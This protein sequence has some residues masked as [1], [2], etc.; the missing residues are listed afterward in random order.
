MREPVA[1]AFFPP[2]RGGEDWSA[3][4]NAAAVGAVT[5]VDVAKANAALYPNLTSCLRE[6]FFG[7]Y[8]ANATGLTFQ[9]LYTNVGGLRDHFAQ[10]W[11]LVASSLKDAS[12]VL[13]FEIINEPW[14]GNIY[15]EHYWFP[16]TWWFDSAYS[17][18]T[19]LT[20]FYRHI[21]AAIREVD[22]EHIIAYEGVM[23]DIWSEGFDGSIGPPELEALSWHAYC[24]WAPNVAP[25]LSWLCGAYHTLLFEVMK[26]NAASQARPPPPP[27]RTLASRPPAEPATA[28]ALCSDR[29]SA[30]ASRRR[31]AGRCSPSSARWATAR[32]TSPS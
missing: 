6:D 31:V 22:R 3:R 29:A 21:A 7:Y 16:Y 9:S 23:W 28:R 14:P 17:E 19:L 1:D 2:R 15:G 5:A 11:R 13:M 10:H 20:P 8:Q 18:R 25:E 12:N 32:W 30:L 27:A 26:S 24:W 4:A